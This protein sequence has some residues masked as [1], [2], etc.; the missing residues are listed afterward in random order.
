MLGIA[1]VALDHN[2]DV[3][4]AR[5]IYDIA[6]PIVRELGDKDR[7]GIVLG[8]SGE[9]ARM[10]GDY[11]KALKLAS[12]AVKLFTEA[13]DHASVGWQY[14]SMAHYYLLQRSYADAVAS[15]RKSWP[16]LQ[17]EPIPLWFAWHFDVWFIILAAL[18]RWDIA[19]KILGF[20]NKYRD[21]H[22]TPRRQGIY[23]W[24]TRP[25]ERL[26]EH[27]GHDRAHE[28]LIE[29]ESL[30]LEQAHELVKDVEA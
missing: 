30:S 13:Q 18:N 9:I 8:N 5:R 3:A 15:M 23:P 19:A 28:L 10:E 16:E 26:S 25:V 4:E 29:G 22:N 11:K 21:D 1:A 14:T 27:L 17:Q 24:F 20:V 6:V 12:E 7:L 2:V